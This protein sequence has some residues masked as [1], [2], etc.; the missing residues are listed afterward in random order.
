MQ[1][2]KKKKRISKYE[3]EKSDEFET[4]FLSVIEGGITCT[5]DY[6]FSESSEKDIDYYFGDYKLGVELYSPSR[7][8]IPIACSNDLSISEEEM[9]KG[10]NKYM[11]KSGNGFIDNKINNLILL[12]RSKSESKHNFEFSKI[13]IILLVDVNRTDFL[14]DYT[15][16]NFKRHKI[17]LFNQ[18]VD[19]LKTES[20]PDHVAWAI[21]SE[22]EIIII[23]VGKKV[24]APDLL[25]NLKKCL[26]CCVKQI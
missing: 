21:R 7:Q 10:M 15:S 16:D 19:K 4:S 9:T 6:S 8:T 3:N 18:L 11:R 14:S 26:S 12:F 13:L 2:K 1:D 24:N 5:R 25:I 22:K 20:I 23:K 17:D